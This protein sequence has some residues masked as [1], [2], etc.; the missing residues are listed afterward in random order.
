MSERI[1][2]FDIEL[3]NND[4]AS[5][6]SIGI[7]EM[8]DFN[9]VS[10]YYSLIK[11]RVMQFD[12]IRYKIHNINI[13]HLRH[14]RR[15]IEV[16]KE[17]KHY[18]DNTIVVSH[19]I[20]VD[21]Y[22]LR[23][24]LKQEEIPFPNI[25]MSCTNVLAHLVHPELIKY[26]LQELANIYGVEFEAHH[27]LEDAK[28]AAY[29]LQSM[30]EEEGLESLKELHQEYHLAFGEMKHNYYRNIISPEM[31]NNINKLPEKKVNDLYH[32]IVCFTGKLTLP[33]EVY[34]QKTKQ[35]SAMPSHQVTTQTNILVVGKKSYFKVRY[36]KRNKKVLKALKL[37]KQGQ[38]LKIIHENEYIRLL[39][40]KKS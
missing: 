7:V 24:T 37:I 18:F 6:C 4:P 11:P 32:N 19:D 39:N 26:N 14:E 33:K 36:G 9:I 3:L 15:F 17:I 12:P 16:W 28:A 27:A 34:E 30:V 23:E 29:I 20:N 2:V 22:H 5:I 10:T 38:D 31:I 1:V 21:M 40:K 35:V 8:I 25:K 13:S